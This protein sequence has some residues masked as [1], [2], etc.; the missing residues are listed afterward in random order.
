[1]SL[2]GSR[3][4]YYRKKKSN[5]KSLIYV[6]PQSAPINQISKYEYHQLIKIN[7][8]N[9]YNSRKSFNTQIV[10]TTGNNNKKRT[11]NSKSKKK[12]E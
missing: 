4:R 11:V 5:E 8:C 9:L 10:P 3:L 6:I 1:M 12:E 2:N 7:I